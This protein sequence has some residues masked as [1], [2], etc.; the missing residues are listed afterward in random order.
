MKPVLFI[1]LI[2]FPASS[3]RDIINQKP[4]RKDGYRGTTLVF[5]F[6]MNMNTLYPNNGGLSE[7]RLRFLLGIQFRSLLRNDFP[8]QLDRPAF[9][10]PDSLWIP[11]DGTLSV[12]AF[13]MLFNHFYKTV[14]QPNL[15]C[16]YINHHDKFIIKSHDRITL[17]LKIPRNCAGYTD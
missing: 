12:N 2:L 3:A 9:T 15:E 17:D 7:S 4:S 5:I 6:C 16:N 14:K 8:R 10:L 1:R 13:R 11:T